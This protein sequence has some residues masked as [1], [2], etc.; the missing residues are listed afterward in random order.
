MRKHKEKKDTPKKDDPRQETTEMNSSHS[1][2]P[3][4]QSRTPSV[5]GKST[6]V[7]SGLI[8]PVE[9][10]YVSPEDSDGYECDRELSVVGFNPLDDSQL[11]VL[12]LCDNDGY[13]KAAPFAPGE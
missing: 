11:K 5:Y 9:D 6:M 3:I 1:A 10:E 13:W 8:S 7:V 12:E 4:D 2:T